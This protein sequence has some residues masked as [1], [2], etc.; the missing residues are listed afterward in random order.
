MNEVV[1]PDKFQ[2]MDSM[3]SSMQVRGST[4]TQLTGIC[5]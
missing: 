4:K 3:I 5:P 2:V 1:G